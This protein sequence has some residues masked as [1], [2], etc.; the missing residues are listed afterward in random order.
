MFWC[1]SLSGELQDENIPSLRT[2]HPFIS[3]QHL[4]PTVGAAPLLLPYPKGV[5]S[6]HARG[7]AW[8]WLFV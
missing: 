3:I 1:V 5:A 6:A 4:A 2:S 7:T 8:E